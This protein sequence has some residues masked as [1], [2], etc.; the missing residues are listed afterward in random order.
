MEKYFDEKNMS[1]E[2]NMSSDDMRER[3]SATL[4]W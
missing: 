2:E 1:S 3:K 4:S